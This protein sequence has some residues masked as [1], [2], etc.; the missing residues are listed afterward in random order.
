MD[1]ELFFAIIRTAAGLD[2]QDN[3][4]GIGFLKRLIEISD[5]YE[6]MIS[7]DFSVRG[8]GNTI[9][10]GERMAPVIMQDGGFKTFLD[11]RSQLLKTG[12]G[13]HIQRQLR[14]FVD[15][16]CQATRDTSIEIPKGMTCGLFD[17][18][19]T[20]AAVDAVMNSIRYKDS[21]L[22]TRAVRALVVTCAVTYP[23]E[24]Q[25]L[26]IDLLSFGLA[27][28]ELIQTLQPLGT[29]FG[30]AEP[31][32]GADAPKTQTKDADSLNIQTKM[33]FF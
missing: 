14:R 25:A 10:L 7:S 6:M 3:V 19:N 24:V 8:S 23:E 1:Q 15:F 26:R 12:L 33:L 4:A 11:I 21:D 20:R 22:K 28:S 2:L 17:A 9:K 31:D 30:T 27:N 32:K 29:I 16:V 13:E 18:I 5:T